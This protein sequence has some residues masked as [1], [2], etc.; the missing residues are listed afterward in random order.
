MTLQ[1]FHNNQNKEKLE[2]LLGELTDE[3]LQI[4]RFKMTRSA[5]HI[6]T[7][8]ETEKMKLRREIIMGLLKR[9]H[10]LRTIAKVAECS[11]EAIRYFTH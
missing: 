7:A 10:T 4:I 2:R 1:E 8:I 3:Q 5:K 9:G 6:P 11:Y